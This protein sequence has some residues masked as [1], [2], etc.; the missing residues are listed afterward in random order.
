MIRFLLLVIGSLCLVI[1]AQD[2]C[3]GNL[4]QALQH[5]AS[6]IKANDP[7]PVQQE[8]CSP[9]GCNYDC[10][11]TDRL[12]SIDSKIDS[13]SASLQQVMVKQEAT[14]VAAV[15]TNATIQ[16]I[17]GSIDTITAKHQETAIATNASIEGPAKQ[18]RRYQD[19]SGAATRCRGQQH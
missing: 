15:A 7:L 6:A 8:K 16:D 2:T 19:R 4:V 3:S 12:D 11:S 5:C 17:Q 14:V 9:N 10:P 18:H 13:L 1:S